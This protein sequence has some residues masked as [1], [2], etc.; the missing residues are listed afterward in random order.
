MFFEEKQCTEG[1]N[2]IK[3]ALK[4]PKL[5][6]ILTELFVPT[7][8]SPQYFIE[9]YKFIVQSN[10]NDQNSEILFVLLYKVS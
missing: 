10:T 1:L 8:T 3:A 9:M 2:L 6:N 5:V 4:K 7:N